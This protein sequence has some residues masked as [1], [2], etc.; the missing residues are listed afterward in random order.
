MQLS[1]SVFSNIII[2]LSRK[3]QIYGRSGTGNREST[4]SRLNRL[5]FEILA[6]NSRAGKSANYG[7]HEVPIWANGQIGGK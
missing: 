6:E 3:S 1:E 7:T 4:S 2:F 5:F